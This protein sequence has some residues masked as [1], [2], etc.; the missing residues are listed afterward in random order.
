VPPY[1]DYDGF[2]QL[3]NGIGSIRNLLSEMSDDVDVTRLPEDLG[4]IRVVTGSL[5][6]RVFDRYVLPMLSAAG[7]KVLPRV[8]CATNEFFG[9]DVTCSGLLIGADMIAAVRNA[10]VDGG[11]VTFIPPNCLNFD[12]VT[13]D[14]MTEDDL[15]RAVGHEMISPG[16]SFI[17]SLRLYAT[18][19]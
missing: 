17:E 18:R 15:S 12:N 2:P 9:A 11:G 4:K 10:G 6:A 19:E 7:V 3:D 14:E 16:E 13:I 5:G 8:I 1:E